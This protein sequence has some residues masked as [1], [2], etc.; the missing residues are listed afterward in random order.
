M[1]PV[2]IT[3]KRNPRL[4]KCHSGKISPANKNSWPNTVTTVNLKSIDISH[5]FGIS[6]DETVWHGDIVD[7][8][9]CDSMSNSIVD[10]SACDSCTKDKPK[11]VIFSSSFNIVRSGKA[12]A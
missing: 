10:N 7:N 1:G 11:R 12:K 2:S 4:T 9:T 8:A 5:M 3:T 6:K